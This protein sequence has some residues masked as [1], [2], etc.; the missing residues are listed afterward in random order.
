MAKGKYEY[1]LTDE[2]LLQIGGWAM[3]TGTGGDRNSKQHAE[4]QD[5]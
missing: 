4:N 5:R 3:R 2:G 1:W